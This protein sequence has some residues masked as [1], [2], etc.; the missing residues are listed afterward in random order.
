MAKKKKKN[1]EGIDGLDEEE[2]GGSKI[3]VFFVALLI[4]LIWIAIFALCVRW[5][6]GG[7]GSS[8]LE[9]VLK[10]V[11]VL[12]KILPD[13]NTDSLIEDEEYPYATLSQAVARIKELESE[14]ETAKENAG[15]D[16]T[17]ISELRAEI[18]RL[19]QYEDA[20]AEFEQL[21]AQFYEEVVYADNAPDIDEYKKYYESIAP[22]RAEE[23]YQQVVKGTQY[24][25][26]IQ[27][28][29]AAYS[30]M[31]PAQAA[32]IFEAMTDNLDL[33]AKILQAMGSDARG[34]ILGAMKQD[35]AAQ[36]TKIMEP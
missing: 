20:Q 18:A 2:K 17:Q 11:P 6:V 32:A 3:V 12:N 24:D 23:L 9:P 16:G 26:Q 30:Q 31:K 36:L 25:E 8:V 33:A 19:K 35:V 22:E 29:A 21:K 1:I 5:D 14:L 10:D 15:S 4:I 28:Y 7:F 34:Q 27:D 13:T